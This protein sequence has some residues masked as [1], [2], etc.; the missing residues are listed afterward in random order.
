MSSLSVEDSSLPDVRPLG[1][2]S[3]AAMWLSDCEPAGIDTLAL[4]SGRLARLRQMMRR[5]DF[6]ALVLFDPYNQRYATGSRNMFGYFLRNST[7]YFFVP[8]EGPIVLFE[9]PQSYH[10]STRLETVDEAR[11]SKLV[12]SS[13][14][15][16]DDQTA[17][18][19]AAEIADLL[20]KAAGSR[21]A[22]VGLDRCG[23]LLA[24]ALEAQGCRVADCQQDILQTRAIKT[25][26][27]VA[28]LQAS[29]AAC[30]GAV[31][32]MQAGLKPGISEQELFADYYGAV[33]RSGGEFVE[34]RLLSSGTRT[35]PWFNEAGGRRLR[36]GELLAL[37]T[38]TIGC[39]GYYSD[40]SR[41]FHCG[42]G[43]PSAAQRQLYRMAYDQ[44]QHNSAVAKPGMTFREIAEAAWAI[45]SRFVEQRYTSV[46]HGVGMHGET[47][48]IAHA[49]D[50]D[51]Y[52]RDGILE[53]GMVVS[54]ESYIGE[55]GGLEGVKLEDEFLVTDRGLRPLSRYPYDED[56]LGREI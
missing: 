16:R 33:I 4:R 35:N 6:A 9:Y 38:D 44:V 23:L 55:V 41:T 19:F 34:T 18:A 21:N 36:P 25:A 30:E 7:R 2:D 54:V 48:F 52:G 42:P 47:P 12:W 20:R 11:P 8:V 14:A 3:A 32:T 50:F 27:E 5:L 28:C 56:L 51:R 15:K 29:M 40:F 10:V 22:K 46:M 49:M 43:R 53:P 26:E 37:D 45:P 1:G 24:Q 13:V 31:A 17:D 39:F